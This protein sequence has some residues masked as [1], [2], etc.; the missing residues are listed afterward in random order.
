M[1]LWRNVKMIFVCRSCGESSV[2]IDMVLEGACGCGCTHFHLVS[3]DRSELPKALEE[4]E[5]IRRDLHRWLDL[6]LDSMSPEV[7]GNIS[8]TFEIG[9]DNTKS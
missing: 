4:K 2:D 5:S 6:N 7:V 3:E 9:K 1:F 8:V